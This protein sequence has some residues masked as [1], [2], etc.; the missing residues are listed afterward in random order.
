M[1]WFEGCETIDEAKKVFRDLCKKY[2]PDLGGSE[3]KMKS[4]NAAYEALLRD[5]LKNEENFEER[6]A[7]EKELAEMIKK[8]IVLQGLVVEIC[9]RWI[10][11]TGDTYS[12]RK[13][14][15]HLGC[16]FA[17]K[18]KAWYWRS[19]D[20]ECRTSKKRR[21]SLEEIRS[22]YG[23]TTLKPSKRILIS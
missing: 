19:K 7:L 3:E 23:S 14:L 13:A 17:K 16:F 15:K 6:M 9:G 11:I 22:K 21:L 8:L 5:G 18:K 12:Q 4:I 1:N 20:D 2:H 10:W